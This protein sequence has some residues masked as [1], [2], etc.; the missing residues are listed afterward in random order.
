MQFTTFVMSLALA[1]SASAAPLA[2]DDAT[3][4]L[5]NDANVLQKRDILSCTRKGPAVSCSIF[6]V[7]VDH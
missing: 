5:T 2:V 6:S 1:L 7:T 4:P 3:I